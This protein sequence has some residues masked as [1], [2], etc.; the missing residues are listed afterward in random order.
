MKAIKHSIN[1]KGLLRILTV[2]NKNPKLGEITRLFVERER[3]RAQ[4][5][6]VK[7]KQKKNTEAIR[8]ATTQKQPE[9]FLFKF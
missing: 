2:A 4:L 9:Q 5:K 3:I 7:E 8:E 6:T 1:A